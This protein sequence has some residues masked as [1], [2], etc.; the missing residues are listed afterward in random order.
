ML[1][2]IRYNDDGGGHSIL[3]LDIENI[4]MNKTDKVPDL[5]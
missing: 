4:A 5:I 2:T 3:I 1:I